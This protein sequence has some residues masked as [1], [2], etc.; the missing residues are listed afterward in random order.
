MYLSLY[1][2]TGPNSFLGGIGLES[3]FGSTDSKGIYLTIYR[4]I[5]YFLSTYVSIY[6]THY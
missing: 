6:L 4:F 2:S 5:S 1:A 3:P